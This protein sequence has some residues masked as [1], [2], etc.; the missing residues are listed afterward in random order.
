MRAASEVIARESFGGTT[1]Q[2]V[3]DAAGVST[4][5]VNHYFAN[6]SDL[7]IQT[8]KHIEAEWQRDIRKATATKSS[9]R[10]KI[11]ELVRAAGPFSTLNKRRWRVW[12][13]AGSEAIRSPGMRAALRETQ[14]S[15]RVV[16]A[17]AFA[18]IVR[19]DDRALLDLEMIARLYDA[20]QNGLFLQFDISEGSRDDDAFMILVDFLSRSVGVA[21]ESPLSSISSPGHSNNTAFIDPA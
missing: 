8:L 6:K 16:M 20:L 12:T 10:A 1:L 3:A 2:K 15:W 13:A 11:E 18:Q 19:E 21:S 9:G 4:G 17:E 14:A 5:T 7:L